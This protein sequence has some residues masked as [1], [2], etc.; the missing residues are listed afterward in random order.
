MVFAT[1]NPIE[2]EGTYQLPEAQLDRFLLKVLIDYP[3]HENEVNVVK[4]AASQA[5]VRLNVRGDKPPVCNAQD[6]IEAQIVTSKIMASD[7]VVDYITRLVR[8]TR[9]TS[10]ISEGAST[11][12]AISLLRCSRAFALMSGRHYVIPDD[13]KQLAPA[14]LRHRVT[15]APEL[16]ISGQTTDQVLRH[17]IDTIEAPRQ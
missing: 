9:E 14:V 5:D 2:Q 8:A 12:G 7:T 16:M 1:Q 6:I 15:L 13:A 17:I 10:A 3:T 4:M 11:R